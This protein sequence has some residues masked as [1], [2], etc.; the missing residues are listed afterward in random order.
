VIV[1]GVATVTSSVTA[2]GKVVLPPGPATVLLANA[3]TAAT[4]YFAAAGTVSTSTGFPVPSGLVSPVTFPIPAGCPA[5]T[6]SC[7]TATGAASLA[8][9]VCSATGQVGVVGTLG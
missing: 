2:A 9:M 8:W 7:V 5:G 6:L 1:T 3:G 4:V